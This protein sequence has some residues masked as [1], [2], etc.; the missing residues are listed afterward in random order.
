MFFDQRPTIEEINGRRVHAFQCN[1]TQCLGKTRGV[2]RYLDTKDA[3]STGNMR[4]HAK[5]CWGDEAVAAADGTGSAIN[6]RAALEKMR[7]KD[8]SITAAFERSATSK[9]TFSHRQHTTIESRYVC[10]TMRLNTV[11]FIDYR[12]EFVR[13]IAESKRPFQIVKDRGF[14]CL[15]KTGR[16]GCYIPSPETI[17]KDVKQVFANVRQRIAQ[18][19]QVRDA[20]SSIHCL[21]CSQIVGL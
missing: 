11:S 10:S 9:I 4:K 17:S 8:G 20:L 7:K 5:V 15:M 12:A 19:L 6:A 13:W 18:M 21:L 14:R 2:R 1:A 16:P 3:K